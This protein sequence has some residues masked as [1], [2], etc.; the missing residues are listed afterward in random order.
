MLADLFPLGDTVAVSV[1]QKDRE[2]SYLYVLHSV[3]AHGLS[4]CVLTLVSVLE[5][6]QQWATPP[7]AAMAYA[8]LRE[9]TKP[10]GL[11]SSTTA[12]ILP[13]RGM[14]VRW[15]LQRTADAAPSRQFK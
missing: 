11:R 1:K 10:V 14:E 9:R 2:L 5:A 4:A 12:H 6:L 7:C 3:C 15:G 8:V 13:S